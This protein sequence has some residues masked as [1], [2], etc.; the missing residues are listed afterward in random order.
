MPCQLHAFNPLQHV[1]YLRRSRLIATRSQRLPL[2]SRLTR[3]LEAAAT[4][5]MIPSTP[6]LQRRTRAT[7]WVVSIA[8]LPSLFT[9]VTILVFYLRCTLLISLCVACQLWR[10]KTACRCMTSAFLLC[11]GILITGLLP[12]SLYSPPDS[13]AEAV[14]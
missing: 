7:S 11:L 13:D 12:P 10:C 1:G 6:S 4:F 2:E 14:D 5:M 9:S 8:I 3:E